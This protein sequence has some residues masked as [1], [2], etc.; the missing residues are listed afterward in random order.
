MQKRETAN[1]E[2]LIIK[3]IRCGPTSHDHRSMMQMDPKLWVIVE[4]LAHEMFCQ[5]TRI[6]MNVLVSP[7]AKSTCLHP[8]LAAPSGQG[9]GRGA[10]RPG[11]SDLIGAENYGVDICV[12]NQLCVCQAGGSGKCFTQKSADEP[13]TEWHHGLDWASVQ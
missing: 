11:T 7:K 8:K 6:R 3:Q 5:N 10:E 1:K 12:E 13:P 4:L 2:I 9:G